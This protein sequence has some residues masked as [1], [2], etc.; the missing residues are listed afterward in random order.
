MS[1]KNPLWYELP[2]ARWIERTNDWTQTWT[3]TQKSKMYAAENRF[4]HQVR[5][6]QFGSVEAAQTYADKFLKSTWVVKRFKVDHSRPVVVNSI[7]RGDAHWSILHSEITLPVTWGFNELVLLHELCH[8]LHRH[9]GGT[10]HGRYF[11]RILLE[12]IGHV[13]GKEARRALIVQYKKGR[14]KYTPRPVYSDETRRAMRI[15]GI[16]MAHQN[17]WEK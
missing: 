17:G 9:D 16:K 1:T 3:D 7:P 15:R 2:R 6:Q 11:A 4:R 12:V 14:V 8:A 5:C 13:F 10:S